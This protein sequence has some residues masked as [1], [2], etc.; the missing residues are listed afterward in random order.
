MD[1]GCR[2]DGQAGRWAAEERNRFKRVLSGYGF[3]CAMTCGERI[4]QELDD[5]RFSLKLV[6]T[7]G[8]LDVFRHLLAGDPGPQAIVGSGCV[9]HQLREGANV[10]VSGPRDIQARRVKVE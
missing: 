9:L 3:G 6:R 5:L 1:D 4:L 2:S 10:A 7:V 8:A